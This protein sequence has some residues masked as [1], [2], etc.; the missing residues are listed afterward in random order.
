[1]KILV[2]FL[3]V[4]AVALIGCKKE[5]NQYIYQFSFELNG[6][7]YSVDSVIASNKIV[8]YPSPIGYTITSRVINFTRGRL[9]GQTD[10]INLIN[11]DFITLSLSCV[12]YSLSQDSIIGSYKTP[13]APFKGKLFAGDLRVYSNRNP[14]RINYNF[15]YEV[16]AIC[17]ISKLENNWI[18]G[19]FS[20]YVRDSNSSGDSLAVSNGRFN[21]PLS[22]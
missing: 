11:R 12:N 15:I 8:D 19:T 16:P 1:M 5:T 18:S 4:V 14:H 22:G 6:K 13:Y 2:I 7:A 21:L 20:G 9:E 17:T 10:S 3:G